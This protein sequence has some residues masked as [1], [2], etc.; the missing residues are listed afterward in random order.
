MR[1]AGRRAPGEALFAEKGQQP[2]SWGLVGMSKT[3]CHLRDR[4]WPLEC[5]ACASVLCPLRPLSGRRQ[6]HTVKALPAVA[7]LCGGP[8][9][10]WL[11]G[12]PRSVPIHSS[13]C[14][15]SPLGAGLAFLD[16]LTGTAYSP[17]LS[18]ILRFLHWNSSCNGRSLC[19][20]LGTEVSEWPGL[21]LNSS[22]LCCLGLLKAK[23]LQLCCGGPGSQPDRR[24][25]MGL[26]N[27]GVMVPSGRWAWEL[28]FLLSRE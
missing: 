27:N 21:F 6:P 18:S 15:P 17:W 16:Q 4:R 10:S 1:V 3:P 7:S 14:V 23:Q 19:Q 22:T 5:R 2:G 24:G 25:G 12:A 20:A 28:C 26:E 13:S 11:S 9:V 8:P